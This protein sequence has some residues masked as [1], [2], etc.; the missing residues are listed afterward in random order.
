M[1]KEDFYFFIFLWHISSTYQVISQLTLTEQ[2]LQCRGL[3]FNNRPGTLAWDVGMGRGHRTLALDV[4]MRHWH[5]TVVW[6]ASMELWHGM[7]GWDVGKKC[8]HGALAWDVGMG[9]WHG[10]LA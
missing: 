7:L 5:G 10:M 3:H 1:A 9:L 8:W 2:H 4:G 6:D